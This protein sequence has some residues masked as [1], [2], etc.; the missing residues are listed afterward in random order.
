MNTPNFEYLDCAI[1]HYACYLFMHFK[2]ITIDDKSVAAVVKLVTPA[3]VADLNTVLSQD[4][5]NLYIYHGLSK[6]LKSEAI[7]LP[8]TFWSTAGATP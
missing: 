1:K 7:F 3:Y 8:L 6:V 2:N 5:L 4:G